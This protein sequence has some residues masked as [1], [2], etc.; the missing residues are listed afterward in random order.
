M[1]PP[2]CRPRHAHRVKEQKER[3]TAA[4]IPPMQDQ[5]EEG[6]YAK[7]AYLNWVRGAE[8]SR[9]WGQIRAHD[10]RPRPVFAGNGRAP[11]RTTPW[12]STKY[13]PRNNSCRNR[14]AS[15]GVRRGTRVAG[16]RCTT[17]D[18]EY[19]VGEALVRVGVR[20]IPVGIA[21]V[22]WGFV[23]KSPGTQAGSAEIGLRADRPRI[24][25]LGTIH[26]DIFRL[27]APL[28]F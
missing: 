21:A 16:G 11:G 23:L 12:S 25:V 19:R 9:P 27:R 5:R 26:P 14:H 10:R 3:M 4:M 8:K 20:W 15:W 28:V 13:R 22:V 6:G 1:P 24:S 2:R 17:G 18:A 7:L